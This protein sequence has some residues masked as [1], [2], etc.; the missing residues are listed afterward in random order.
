M[1]KT[2]SLTR[3]AGGSSSPRKFSLVIKI[4]REE[5]EF[6]DP[7]SVSF[8][9]LFDLSVPFLYTSK[10]DANLFTSI[11]INSLTRSPPSAGARFKKLESTALYCK[12]IKH[13]IIHNQLPI[14]LFP[15]QAIPR[16]ILRAYAG[17]FILPLSLRPRRKG[18]SP[19]PRAGRVHRTV[20]GYTYPPRSCK[21]ITGLSRRRGLRY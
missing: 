20:I 12:R 13:W 19:P 9:S 2:N 16:Q 15:K 7:P 10:F 3:L 11:T 18:K 5:G 14:I 21:S 6:R 17:F 8:K 4:T 1:C